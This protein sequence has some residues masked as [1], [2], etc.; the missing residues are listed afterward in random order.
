MN[1]QATIETPTPTLVIMEKLSKATG[2]GGQSVKIINTVAAVVGLE[3]KEM[4]QAANAF[5]KAYNKASTNSAQQFVVEM[6]QTVD[7]VEFF[8]ATIAAQQR[9]D[10]LKKTYGKMP[11]SL[12]RQMAENGQ[13]DADEVAEYEVIKAEDDAVKAAAKTK[14]DAEAEK[15]KEAEGATTE[16]K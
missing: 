16:A 4:R 11:D 13:L 2:K 3:S 10:Y 6:I 14:K 9:V 1:E 7:S 8:N 5:C 15:T 12:R